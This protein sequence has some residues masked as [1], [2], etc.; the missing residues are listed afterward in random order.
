[1]KIYYE[2]PWKVSINVARQIQMQLRNQ[3]DL[4]TKIQPHSINTLAAADISHSPGDKYLSAAVVLVSF[5]Q[6]KVIST[7]YAIDTINFPYIPGLLSFR[8]V[9]LLIKIFQKICD[10]FDLLLC[11]GHGIAHPR[12]FGIACH[13]GTLLNKP[14]LGCA[15]SRLIGHYE[16]PDLKKGSF[17]GLYRE[18]EQIGVVLRTRENVKPVFVSPGHQLDVDT[19]REV[20]LNCVTRYRIPEPLRFAHQQVNRFRKQNPNRIF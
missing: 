7:Y 3:V 13:L 11:D 5:P 14:A 15:K 4:T 12:Q 8:E 6:L 18:K 9:P 19:A 1:M 17:T 16:E 10:D 20:A 2:H